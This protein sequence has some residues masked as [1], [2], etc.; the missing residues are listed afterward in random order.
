MFGSTLNHLN[1]DFRSGNPKVKSPKK[2]D[3]QKKILTLL[4]KLDG[5]KTVFGCHPSLHSR[6]IGNV[7]SFGWYTSRGHGPDPYVTTYFPWDDRISS[8]RLPFSVSTLYD[9][10]SVTTL[11]SSPP[12]TPH[13][14][15][16]PYYFRVQSPWITRSYRRWD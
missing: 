16:T 12:L 13:S 4:G 1:L 10:F 3:P 7:R 8:V 14:F 15:H 2:D 5:N 6:S 9:Y 11:Y